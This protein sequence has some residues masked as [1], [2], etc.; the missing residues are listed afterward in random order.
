MI[1]YS[2]VASLTFWQQIQPVDQWLITHINQNWSSPFFDTI[3]LYARETLTWTPLY[4]FLLVFSLLNFGNRAYFW[5]IGVVLTA[6]LSD[7]VSSQVIKQHIARVRPCQ[8]PAVSPLLRIFINYCPSSSS[9]TSSHATT[10][11]AQAVFFFLT[12]RPVIGRWSWLFFAWAGLVSYS[13]VYAGVH[14]PFDVL[15]GAILGCGIGFLVAK[16]FQRQVGQLNVS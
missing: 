13:Q 11:F 1:F 5:I 16:M 4:I 12:L 9:F 3:V 14:Y 10:H 2:L 6:A 7:L 15:C 8:D